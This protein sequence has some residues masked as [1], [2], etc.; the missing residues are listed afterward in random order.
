MR[1]IATLGNYLA[2]W[3]DEGVQIHQYAPALIRSA[4][5]GVALRMT[6]DYPWDS[7]VVIDVED[8]PQAEWTLALRLPAWCEAP[9]LRVDD[10][11]LTDAYTPG[12]YLTVRRAWR[13][14][15]RVTL[16]LPMPVRLT[17]GNPRVDAQRGQVAIERGPLVYCLEACDH[18]DVE[19]LDVRI[20]AAAPALEASWNQDLLGGVMTVTAMGQPTSLTAV[21]YYAWANRQPGA[22]RVWVPVR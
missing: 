20:D 7:Q 10:Q 22:M 2:T 16:D 3:S 6:T 19:L 8:A 1:L 18:P 4:E 21:P 14:G 9:T 15:D 5:H 17:S 13:A 11:V 12:G